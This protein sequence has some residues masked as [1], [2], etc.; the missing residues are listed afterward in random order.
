MARVLGAEVF[1]LAVVATIAN[2]NAPTTAELNAGTFLTSYLGDGGISTPLDGS[3]VD[4]A[5]MSSKYNKTIAGTY[6]GQPVTLEFFRD[7]TADDAWT[8]LPRGTKTHIVIARFGLAT[9][10]TFAVA[11]VVDV[12]PIEVITRNPMDV[13]RNEAQKF[14]VECGVSNVPAED[15]SIAA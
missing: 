14:T 2:Y 6:G 3:L 12:W 1:E 10:G 11:D 7:D 8:A 13:V 15:Y 5:D 9:P 4:T